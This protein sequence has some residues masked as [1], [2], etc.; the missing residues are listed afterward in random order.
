MAAHGPFRIGLLVYTLKRDPPHSHFDCKEKEKSLKTEA[1]LTPTVG[2][3]ADAGLGQA[4]D[5]IASRAGL[6]LNGVVPE[7]AVSTEGGA[8]LPLDNAIG[9]LRMAAI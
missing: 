8:G 2:M 1:S 6:D 5:V 7:A 3:E 9:L 4:V